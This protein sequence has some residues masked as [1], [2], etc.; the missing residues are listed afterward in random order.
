MQSSFLSYECFSKY[1]AAIWSYRTFRVG[2]NGDEARFY[3]A[4]SPF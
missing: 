4:S 3:L 2:F 1:E